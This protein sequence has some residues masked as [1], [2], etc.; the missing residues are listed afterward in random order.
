VLAVVALVAAGFGCPTP[1]Q[2][3]GLGN[4]D[5]EGVPRRLEMLCRAGHGDPSCGGTGDAGA[6][7]ID[8]AL[9]AFE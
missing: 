3:G 9:D 5:I 1:A 2:E 7:T 8:A 6:D 4:I